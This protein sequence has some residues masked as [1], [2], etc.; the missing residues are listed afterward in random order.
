MPGLFRQREPGRWGEVD[1][2]RA[3]SRPAEGRDRER[4][5]EA[6]SMVHSDR[7]AHHDADAEPVVRPL[8]VPP[9]SHRPVECHTPGAFSVMIGPAKCS[10][11]PPRR[12]ARSS[13][14]GEL[15]RDA[16]PLRVR[17]LLSVI[18]VGELSKN[19]SAG[20]GG[21]EYG[22]HMLVEVGRLL[23]VGDR[24]PAAFSG[25]PLLG[26]EPATVLAAPALR[27]P[28]LGP[29]RDGERLAATRALLD[30][31]SPS[32]RS[33]HS[34]TVRGCQRRCLPTRNPFGPWPAVRQE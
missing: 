26:G 24:V 29:R 17:Q 22:A 8:D 4:Q 15:V 23:D 14:A 2:G 11:P 34:N 28:R 10:P 16:A 19:P 12:L 18:A 13:Q 20:T 7:C 31:C 32:S 9:R 6:R 25:P 1:R 30:H 5:L 21:V 33:D 3:T 27:A